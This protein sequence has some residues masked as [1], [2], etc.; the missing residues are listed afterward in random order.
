MKLDKEII[1]NPPPFTNANGEIVNPPP[2]TFKDQLVVSYLDNPT[3]RFVSAVI[4]GIPS[5]ILLAK[6]DEY[7][8]LGEYTSAEIERALKNKLGDDPAAVLRSFFPK[9]LEENPNG[10]GSILSNMLSSIGIKSSPSCAC[11]KHALEMNEKGPD[12][13]EQNMNTILAWLKDEST[14]R[15][16]PFIESVAKMMINKAISK[17]REY[18]NK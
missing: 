5:Q 2:I 7:D 10:A 4:P 16:L 15:K 18:I 3:N 1:I 6:E 17:A 9:T 13:C 12:W 14:K 8:A 11:R